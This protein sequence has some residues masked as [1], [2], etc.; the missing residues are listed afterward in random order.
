MNKDTEKGVRITVRKET[1]RTARATWFRKVLKK[2]ERAGK[3][4]TKK[5][6]GS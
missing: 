4:S 2:R 3:K 1:C 6:M 5:I